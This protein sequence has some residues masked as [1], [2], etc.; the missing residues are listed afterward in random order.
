MKKYAILDINSG[1]FLMPLPDHYGPVHECIFFDDPDE[2]RAYL[3]HP[4][5]MLAQ[6]REEVVVPVTFVVGEPVEW[7]R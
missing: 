7:V 1:L 6:G 3:L 4:D 2:A 5:E